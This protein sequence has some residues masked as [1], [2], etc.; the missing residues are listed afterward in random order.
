MSKSML[1]LNHEADI[2]DFRSHH[3]ALSPACEATFCVRV[4]YIS[5]TAYEVVVYRTDLGSTQIMEPIY[6]MVLYYNGDTEIAHKV[7]VGQCNDCARLR[8]NVNY[9]VFPDIIEPPRPLC[10]GLPPPQN[11]QKLSLEQFNETFNTD[12]ATLPSSLYAIG[13]ITQGP[14]HQWFIYNEKFDQ[15]FNIVNVAQFILRVREYRHLYISNPA[16]YFILSAC[17]GYGEGTYCTQRTIPLQIKGN[18]CK[19]LYTFTAYTE[20]EYPVYHSRKHIVCQSSHK[21]MPYVV[22]VVDR[23]YMYHNLYNS[24]R[25][26][27]RGIA[28][29]DKFPMVVFGG[30]SLCGSNY[31]FLQST[32][33]NMNPRDYFRNVIAPEHAF[34]H[35]P[36]D[37]ITREEQVYYKYIMDIDGN[38]STYDATAWKLNSN[39]IIFKPKSGWTQWFYDEYCSPNKY[40]IEIKD[41]FS[42]LAE[43]F[44]WCESHPTECM[45]IISNC[46]K[47]FQRIYAFSAVIDNTVDAILTLNLEPN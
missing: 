11:F 27:H 22:N 18:T 16:F 5:S 10:I 42:D 46:R 41:D 39:S 38:A 36:N 25:S 28:F 1:A 3:F 32:S 33:I 20:K 8:V 43:K 15:Y 6:V 24:F 17:D 7:C 47:L 44:E 14:I 19:D 40:F 23:H 31:N 12:I 9:T 2:F 13:A 29:K 37:W 45:Q 4:L 26:F 34:V 30:R 21:N 35:C